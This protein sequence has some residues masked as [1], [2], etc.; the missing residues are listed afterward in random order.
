VR[1]TAKGHDELA[2]METTFTQALQAH[3]LDRLSAE[4]LRALAD[5]AHAL[6]APDC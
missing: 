3:F 4:Q 6:G 5:I 2:A 1:L